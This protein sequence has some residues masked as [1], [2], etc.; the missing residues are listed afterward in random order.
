MAEERGEEKQAKM[1]D[2]ARMYY[3]LDYS[4]QE[5]AQKLGVSRPTVS[6][7]LQQAKDEGIVQIKI[8]DPKENNSHYAQQLEHK[9]RLKKAVVVSVPQYD[10]ST[11]KKYLGEAAALYLHEIVKDGDTI[12]ATWGTTLYEVATR[13]QNKHVRG[14]KVVQLNGGVSHTN[15]NTYAHEIVHLFGKAFHT[16]PY[17]IPLPAIVDHSVVKLAIEADRH[18]RSILEMGKQANIAMVTVGAPTEDSV[19]I[20]ADYFSESDLRMIYE[21]GAGDICSRYIDIQGK[22]ISAELNQRTIGI[23]LEELQQ[24]E[25][26]I[27]V[28]GGPKKVDAVYGALNGKYTNVLITDSFTAKYLLEREQ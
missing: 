25:Q 23:D 17:F 15:T 24:K 20:K 11:V 28:A 22:L 6:R 16:N 3:Q 8:V 12:A 21:K 14:V 13:L 10:D 5:I 7:F 18:I 1:V 26:S 27:L 2:A 4:Q 9:F 19:L